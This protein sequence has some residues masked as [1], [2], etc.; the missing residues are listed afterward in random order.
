MSLLEGCSSLPDNQEQHIQQLLREKDP[1]KAKE[2]IDFFKSYYSQNIEMRKLATGIL[3][4]KISEY[5]NA[6]NSIERL[7]QLFDI[8][9]VRRRDLRNQISETIRKKVE[10]KL[11]TVEDPLYLKRLYIA[12][13]EPS[14]KLKIINKWD[15]LFFDEIIFNTLSPKEII[16]HQNQRILFLIL[17]S[18]AGSQCAEVAERIANDVCQ[19]IVRV[20][21]TTDDICSIQLLGKLMCKEVLMKFNDSIIQKLLSTSAE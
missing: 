17:F 12:C 15:R 11:K 10:L 7:K 6:E 5:L 21:S 4:N 19:E 9:P 8:T 20:A 1:F 3:C 16:E 18:P 13:V 2:H 14:T